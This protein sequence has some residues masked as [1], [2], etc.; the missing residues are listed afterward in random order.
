MKMLW[1]LV[2]ILAPL[3]AL[4]QTT[5]SSADSETVES[6]VGADATEQQLAKAITEHGESRRQ[7]LEQLI[8][9]IEKHQKSATA[10]GDLDSVQKCR[11][12][13]E[14]IRESETLPTDPEF[15][16]A[17]SQA[18]KSTA[19]AEKKLLAAYDAAI[20]SYTR[21]KD[22]NKAEAVAQK[23]DQFSNSTSRKASS[24]PTAPEQPTPK[25]VLSESLALYKRLRQISAR[26]KRPP[27]VAYVAKESLGE[28]QRIGGIAIPGGRACFMPGRDGQIV[29]C[30]PKTQEIKSIRS[31]SI[32]TPGP[33]FGAVYAA[34]DS[35]G[36]VYGIPHQHRQYM[37]LNIATEEVTFFGNTPRSECFWG[38]I[39]GADGR[40]YC[41]PSHADRVHRI[42]PSNDAVEPIGEHLG[43][44]GYKYSGGA[45]AANGSIYCFPDNAQRILKID[46]QGGTTS[47]VGPD[48]GSGANKCSS[49]V[50][51]PNGRL[52]GGPGSRDHVLV[53]DP[54]TESTKTIGGIAALAYGGLAL[55][56]DG[57]IYII[58]RNPTTTQIAVLDPT[59]D[60]IEVLR[61]PLPKIKADI[62]GLV[63]TSNGILV[64]V[65]SNPK[66]LLF[67]DFA[68]PVPDSVALS[69]FLNHN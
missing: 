23:K 2:A 35:G 4:G 25:A 54:A 14:A 28:V 6:D 45:M 64:G 56:P 16:N 42:A 31:A 29:I 22:Y 49:A 37:K 41:I 18:E 24:A 11:S 62:T 67:I 19:K 21:N 8:R 43:A 51:A 57:R 48:L 1:L 27:S 5:P 15:A 63:L 50:L 13:I 36:F 55:G 33:F 69:P 59:R 66:A 65:P 34:S 26:I 61:H 38:G 46:P 47:L 12:S 17:R 60:S 20:R 68:V 44:A 40:I 30:D 3:S 58:P 7:A 10:K 52:Y 9:S 39:L 32:N 53:F